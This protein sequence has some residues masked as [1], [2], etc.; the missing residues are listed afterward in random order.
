M[1]KEKGY[2]LMP[3][4]ERSDMQ[5]IA[6]EFAPKKALNEKQAFIKLYRTN[7][8]DGMEGAPKMIEI[9]EK[10]NEA[11]TNMDKKQQK[12]VEKLRRRL[13]V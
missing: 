7:I 6:A 13:D 1:F 10:V 3:D 4:G 5:F 11:F 9:N 12:A 2:Y 8:R